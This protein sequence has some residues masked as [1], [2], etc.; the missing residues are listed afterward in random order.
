MAT[1]TIENVFCVRP[2][3]G[4]DIDV[5]NRLAELAAAI[6]PDVFQLDES[7]KSLPAV[8]AAIDTA[9]EYPDDLYL[10]RTPYNGLEN[11]FWP[12]PDIE[13]E[14]SIEVEA[15]ASA[16]VNVPIDVEF[17]QNIS[18]W[19]EDLSGHEHLG[20]FQIE[21]GDRGQGS[22]AKLAKN[23]AQ[24]SAYYVTYRVD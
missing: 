21:E 12:R 1:A 23:E 13:D 6:I 15:G 7:I 5:L 22:L 10:T 8:A 19:D 2:S 16:P 18:L 4:T 20:S 17:P 9:G 3:S 24:G 11:S 14:D